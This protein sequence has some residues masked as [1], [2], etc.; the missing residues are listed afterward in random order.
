MTDKEKIVQV[1][2]RHQWV[3]DE[4][5]KGLTHADSLLQLPFRS[6]RFNWI[7][8][9]IVVYRDKMLALMK[10]P[11]VLGSKESEIYRRG[12]EPLTTG[13]DAVELST[14]LESTRESLE[15]L[16][17]AIGFNSK[18]VL[19]EIHDEEHGTT[20]QDRLEFLVWHETYHLGQL[21]ILR[22][23]AGKDDAII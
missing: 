18:D 17:T 5:S 9:H 13:H 2:K 6:N 21:E 16:T 14:L 12:S 3:I 4:Q 7:I 8:G 1:L 23:L 11:S 20:I 10:E 19:E 22:Q 15:R